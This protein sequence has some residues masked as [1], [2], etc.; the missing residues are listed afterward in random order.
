MIDNSRYTGWRAAS[1]NDFW[2]T[3]F[4]Q[5]TMDIGQQEGTNRSNSTYDYIRVTH[6]AEKYTP[7]P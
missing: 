3:M 6:Q 5:T 7:A 4:A 1:Y 2:S